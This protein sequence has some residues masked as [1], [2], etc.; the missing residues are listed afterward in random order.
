M[1]TIRDKPNLFLWCKDDLNDWMQTI[2]EQLNRSQAKRCNGTSG[3]N[4]VAGKAVAE[5]LAQQHLS[6]L[7][8]RLAQQGNMTTRVMDSQHHQLEHQ[9]QLN[10]VD[11]ANGMMIYEN[12]P[13]ERPRTESR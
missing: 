13:C 5:L 12:T 4:I 3:Q 9:L 1:L 10:E 8:T 6:Q 7:N 2:G 11:Q